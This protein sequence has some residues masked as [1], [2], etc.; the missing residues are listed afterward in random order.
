VSL[1]VGDG[2][3]LAGNHL[4][5]NKQNQVAQPNLIPVCL[6][7][8]FPLSNNNGDTIKDNNISNWW[9]KIIQ[10]VTISN[11]ETKRAALHV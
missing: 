9:H 1:V 3:L 6:A 4:Q 7:K 11:R 5:P 8:R 10:R 2:F